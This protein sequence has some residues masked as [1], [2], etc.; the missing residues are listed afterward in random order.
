M[1]RSEVL[2]K[3]AA[4]GRAW[5]GQERWLCV[6]SEVWLRQTQTKRDT[7]DARHVW[8]AGQGPGT[9]KD[10]DS[11]SGW[12]DEERSPHGRHP[13]QLPQQPL[14]HSS[15]LVSSCLFYCGVSLKIMSSEKFISTH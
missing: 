12:S 15:S 7:K 9:H 1:S 4:A 10:T 2:L 11:S 13:T 6:P 3:P 14:A 5:W 8:E